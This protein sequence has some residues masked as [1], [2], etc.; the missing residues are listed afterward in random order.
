M[1]Q[2]DMS[3]SAETLDYA[4]S[5]PKPRTRVALVA[6]LFG[7]VCL[8]LEVVNELVDVIPSKGRSGPGRK[9]VMSC[10]FLQ[11]PL[12]VQALEPASAA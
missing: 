11:R 1:I 7:L 3:K 10:Y 6:F 8:I 12:V 4:A 5:S 2:H 9:R